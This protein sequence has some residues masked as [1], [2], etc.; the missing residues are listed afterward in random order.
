MASQEEL[1]SIQMQVAIRRQPRHAS[2]LNGL[3]SLLEG[4]PY[5]LSDS[6][7][8]VL[9]QIDAFVSGSKGLVAKPPRDAFLYGLCAVQSLI[10]YVTWKSRP[11]GHEV[12]HQVFDRLNSDLA[13]SESWLPLSRYADGY[14]SGYRGLTWWTSSDRITT[15]VIRGA[16]E[17]GLVSVPEFAIVLRCPAEYVLGIS[18]VPTAIDGFLFEA[19]HPT[20]DLDSPHWGMAIDLHDGHNLSGG[21]DQYVVGPIEAGQVSFR[22]VHIDEGM[23]AALKVESGPK[24]WAA[25]E[26]Y[27]N[28]L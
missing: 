1:H 5:D 11:S 17:L 2:A 28:T 22:P 4:H 3:S 25:L 27:Y 9:E 19:F 23:R 13:S 6:E 14:L 20:K 7:L 24:L 21:P 15:D 16:L 18:R 12:T 10:N 26:T 8:R